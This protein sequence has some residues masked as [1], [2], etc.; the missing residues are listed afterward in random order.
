MDFGSIGFDWYQNKL[1]VCVFG[2]VCVCVCVCVFVCV[3]IF[4]G[5]GDLLGASY[6]LNT[7]GALFMQ[8]K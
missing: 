8:G 2:C 7:W 6:L 3:Y 4:D 5:L 1:L